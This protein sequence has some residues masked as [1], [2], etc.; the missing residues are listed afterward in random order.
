MQREGLSGKDALISLKRSDEPIIEWGRHLYG[1]HPWDSKLYDLVIRTKQIPVDFAVDMICRTV[2]LESFHTTPESQKTADDLLLSAG[3]KW[4]LIDLNPL[5]EVFSDD[6]S[7]TVKIVIETASSESQEERD[8][9]MVQIEKIV[10]EIPG[11][12][13]VKIDAILYPIGEVWPHVFSGFRWFGQ[14][15]NSDQIGTNCQLG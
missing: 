11:V 2:E 13:D 5:A 1:V 4:A 14:P 8:K 15:S 9:L 7:V 10:K 3:A 12:K 6:G